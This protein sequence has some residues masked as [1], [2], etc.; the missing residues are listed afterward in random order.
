MTYATWYPSISRAH[1]PIPL[2]IHF[3][4]LGHSVARPS[5][6]ANYPSITD[7]SQPKRTEQKRLELLPE[8]A[9]YLI[10]RGTLAC[11]L[12]YDEASLSVAGPIQPPMSVQQ[13][14]ASMI[15][16]ADL[17]LEKYQ[18][19]A[20]LKRL[21][22]VVTRAEPPTPAY[23][24]F[25]RQAK[26]ATSTVTQTGWLEKIFLFLS[27]PFTSMARLMHSSHIDWW[28]PVSLQGLK[29]TSSC[30]FR[31]HHVSAVYTDA[32]DVASLFQAIRRIA[33]PAGHAVPLIQ[34]TS[35]NSKSPYK[36]FYNLYKPVTPYKK[37]AP[38]EPD[39]EVVVIE[40]AWL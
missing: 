31:L 37:T 30:L 35:S 21:G 15:G 8:E 16:T 32:C 25:E 17:T 10:E 38:A 18:V 26:P 9:L 2:G 28:K 39:F 22:Y 4:S 11:S 13:A 20:Y 12:A 29:P 7:L 3:A 6:G 36:V 1:V 14:Y 34:D 23:P 40:Y 5:A 33:S 27:F 19:F 24:G